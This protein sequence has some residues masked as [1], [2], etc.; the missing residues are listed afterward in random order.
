MIRSTPNFECVSIGFHTSSSCL[1]KQ[2]NENTVEGFLG[3][4]EFC[5]TDKLVRNGLVE[6]RA[7]MRQVHMESGTGFK[8]H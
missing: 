5:V 2:Q 4:K 6:G 7:C 8:D 1:H 3:L